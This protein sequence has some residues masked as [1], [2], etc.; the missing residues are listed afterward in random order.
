MD[1]NTAYNNFKLTCAE[2]KQ[3]FDTLLSDVDNRTKTLALAKIV[4]VVP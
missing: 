2:I 3:D 1:I 4:A